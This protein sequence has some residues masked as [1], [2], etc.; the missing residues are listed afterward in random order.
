MWKRIFLFAH[1][2]C[3]YVCEEVREDMGGREGHKR[4]SEK[5]AETGEMV[6]ERDGR[7][8]GGEGEAR[9]MG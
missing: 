9:E 6:D 3:V 2:R 8:G 1:H 4:T 7:G 5:L